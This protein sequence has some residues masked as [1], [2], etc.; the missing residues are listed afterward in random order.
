MQIQNCFKFPKLAA[1]NVL[2]KNQML[3][4][5]M[6][7]SHICW[8]LYLII[9]P[10]GVVKVLL[11]QH[12]Q[13]SLQKVSRKLSSSDFG[14]TEKRKRMRRLFIGRKVISRARVHRKNILA[15]MHPR[16]HAT[17]INSPRTVTALNSAESDAQN[18]PL[19]ITRKP[20]CA[21]SVLDRSCCFCVRMF[22]L[23][24]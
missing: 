6:L 8:E 5:N 14:C 21:D 10:A 17:H 15:Q 9:R 23:P 20:G 16:L 22:R 18:L 24:M 11:A 3:D 1:D 2:R 4:D 7:A 12:V 13:L 19:N